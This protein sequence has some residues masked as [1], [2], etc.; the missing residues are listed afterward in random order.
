MQGHRD[1]PDSPLND[2]RKHGMTLLLESE[3]RGGRCAGGPAVMQNGHQ[4][5]LL[6]GGRACMLSPLLMKSWTD[7]LEQNEEVRQP[8]YCTGRNHR[9]STAGEGRLGP[10]MTL[11]K[12]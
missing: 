3:R 10:A 4:G 7:D 2:L 12:V 9:E 5:V 11:P 6:V 1:A 8:K